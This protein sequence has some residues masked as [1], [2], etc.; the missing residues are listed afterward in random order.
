MNDE[1][2]KQNQPSNKIPMKTIIVVLAMLLAEGGLIIGALFFFAGPSSVQAVQLQDQSDAMLAERTREIPLL[3]EKF[4]NNRRGRLWIYD[5]E[6]ILLT[7]EVHA[8]SVNQQIEDSRAQIRAGVN[9]IIS[10]AQPSYF[11]EPGYETIRRQIL[12]YLNGP[13]DE[14]AVI[15]AAAE[16]EPRVQDVLIPSCIGFPADY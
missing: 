14:Q 10:A 9:R 11:E 8:D 3:H 5:L 6:V 15:P 7:K 2:P 13:T 12:E 4:T 1:A 16:G